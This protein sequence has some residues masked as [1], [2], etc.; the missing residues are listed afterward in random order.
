MF[1]AFVKKYDIVAVDM[2]HKRTRFRS[3]ERRYSSSL[4]TVNLMNV[5]IFYYYLQ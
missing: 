5:K 3:A 2:Y 1:R 4:S